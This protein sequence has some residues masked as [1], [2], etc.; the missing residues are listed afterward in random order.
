MPHLRRHSPRFRG[1]YV[2]KH[3]C[4]IH[5]WCLW[6]PCPL[7]LVPVT[8]IDKLTEQ[9]GVRVWRRVAEPPVQKVPME[10]TSSERRAVL[11]IRR[12]VGLM[13]VGA[14]NSIYKFSRLLWSPMSGHI[15]WQRFS[16]LH[17]RALGGE[18]PEC[19]LTNAAGRAGKLGVPFTGPFGLLQLPGE[20]GR[21]G[22]RD[23][24]TTVFTHYTC[25]LS[26]LEENSPPLVAWSH[27]LTLHVRWAYPRFRCWAPVRWAALHKDP[28]N[29]C[30]TPWGGVR[31]V[32]DR[33]S[34]ICTVS[35]G[36]PD[37]SAAGLM[38]GC[39]V[40][41]SEFGS[42]VFSTIGSFGGCYQYLASI[43]HT[44]VGCG[45]YPAYD[46]CSCI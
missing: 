13:V 15:G 22:C 5:W 46:D 24:V 23:P 4:V 3:Y 8:R 39:F 31:P 40:C 30:S 32:W 11:Q 43:F 10:G 14:G 33:F 12:F 25:T 29:N 44:P 1:I 21:L 9:T 28:L 18:S 36:F 41:C 16:S 35:L 20:T 42:G 19:C 34:K 45:T 37:L 2:L 17:V 6:G 26:G 38:N 7:Q 27:G